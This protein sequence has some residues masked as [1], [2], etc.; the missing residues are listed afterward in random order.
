MLGV[1]M[2]Q[3]LRTKSISMKV[4]DYVSAAKPQV[5]SFRK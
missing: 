1:L 5:A 2:C 4:S 3:G